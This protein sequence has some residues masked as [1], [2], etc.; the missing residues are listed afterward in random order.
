MNCNKI[1]MNEYDYI[2]S[3]K[4]V[5]VTALVCMSKIT[6][7]D[8]MP[9][10][11]EVLKIRDVSTDTVEDYTSGEVLP[12]G[13]YVI[14]GKDIVGIRFINDGF[15]NIHVIKNDKQTYAYKMCIGLT[16]LK[17]FTFEEGTFKHILDDDKAW[18]A[19]YNLKPKPKFT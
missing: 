18:F 12:K 13:E 15:V 10:I 7:E 16:K 2:A 11:T 4:T 6:C 1:N 9:V 17:S 19:C 5:G 8:N 3:F 14:Y